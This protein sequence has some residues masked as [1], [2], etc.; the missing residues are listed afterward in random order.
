MSSKLADYYKQAAINYYLTENFCSQGKYAEKYDKLKN[1]IAGKTKFQPDIEKRRF[2]KMVEGSVPKQV[3][4][5]MQKIE[6][7]EF[8]I[9]QIVSPE[10]KQKEIN[11]VS[12]KSDIKAHTH[13]QAEKSATTAAIA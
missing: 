10:H 5:A 4:E 1:K 7:Q 11:K 12:W 6:A 13:T 2:I 9:D 8:M 3:L